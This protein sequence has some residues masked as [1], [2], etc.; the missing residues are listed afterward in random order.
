MLSNTFE[1]RFL[2][3]ALFV[4][5]SY[6]ASSTASSSLGQPSP[7]P[8]GWVSPEYEWIFEF[9]LPI[10]PVK[11]VKTTY[12][13]YS[14]GA[15]IDYYEV[16]IKPFEQQI[17][18]NLNKTQLVGYDG[19]SPG[20]TFEMT[21]GRE[22]VVRFSNNAL[23]ENSVHVHGQYDRSPFDG[24]AADTTQSGQYKDYYYP[25]G[26][27]ARTLWYHDH[28]E[29]ITANNAYFGQ[30]GFYKISDAQENA[31]GLPSGNYD[32]PLALS[33]KYY[34]PDGSLL[35]TTNNNAGLWGDV[36]HVNGQPWPYLNVE[37]RK[38][39]FRLLDASV[40]RT[41]S[42]SFA[43][44]G[45][46]GES[47]SFNV[48]A[49][50]SVGLLSIPVETTTLMLAMGERYEII[51]DFSSY[52]GKNITLRNAR[53]VGENVDY[54][55]TDKIM[56]F[57]VGNKVTSQA[58]NGNLPST[59]RS[60]PF[61]PKRIEADKDFTF[62]RI[63][64]EWLVNGEGFADIKHRILTRPPRGAVEIWNVHNGAGGGTHP[65]HIHLIDFQI[66]SRTGGRGTVLP[67]EAAGLKDIVYLGPGE[68]AQVIA[69]Y[70]PWDGVYMFH[71]HNLIHE[72][73]DM[74]VAMNVTAL[75]KWGYPPSTHFIDPMEPEFRPRPIIAVDFTE[76]AIQKKLAWL[77]STDA[78]DHGQED[79]VVSS[80][81]ACWSISTSAACG[82]A[83][84]STSA[85]TP[86]T[87]SFKTT[88]T[89]TPVSKSS[90]SKSTSTSGTY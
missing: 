17:Y 76:D 48:V 1:R 47:I 67:Y 27:N 30:E 82:D 29:F 34:N 42:L 66:L 43:V 22:A 25:N 60:V 85:F 36:I 31:I 7:T 73:H 63:G 51:V 15:V 4:R 45:L 8:L 56:R 90:S 58:N 65:V 55:A 16:T 24:W 78:Y 68:S 89:T 37:P 21:R 28:A 35:F 49:S 23:K 19:I 70:A 6:A 9:P 57:V 50:D 13:N 87:T 46:D 53:G 26:Q 86:Q 33:A 71:C 39:R 83:G 74:L 59:L 14:T 75:A 12:T 61:P 52:S 2:L 20:P 40:S 64:D 69:R 10:P 5:S 79:A 62:S 11:S 88:F 44:D 81:D 38:Y 3:L 54:A 72:D 84:G 77:Y 80:L 18:P 32:I 41:Y